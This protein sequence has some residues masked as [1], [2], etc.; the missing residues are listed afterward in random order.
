MLQR[1]ISLLKEYGR[2]LN[3]VLDY[4]SGPGPVMVDLLREAGYDA[5]GWD[6]FFANDPATIG[7]GCGVGCAAGAAPSFE[8]VVSVETFEHFAEPRLEME[9]IVG[10]LRSDGLLIVQT[11]FHHGPETIADWWYVR[12][13]THVAFYSHATLDWICQAFGL[14]MIFQDEKNLAVLCKAK[15]E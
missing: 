15:S 5:T 10:L 11:L 1:V 9:R 13:P 12:D 8:A 2:N 3:R 4:G 14:T 7:V 6:P